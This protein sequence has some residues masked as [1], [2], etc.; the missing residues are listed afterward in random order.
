[1][2]QDSDMF[3]DKKGMKFFDDRRG[4]WCAVTGN[5]YTIRSDFE[6]KPKDV[7]NNQPQAVLELLL[8]KFEKFGSVEKAIFEAGRFIDGEF[9]CVA[10]IEG[11]IGVFSDFIGS[12]PIWYIENEVGT[13]RKVFEDQRSSVLCHGQSLVHSLGENSFHKAFDVLDLKKEKKELFHPT[14]IELKELFEDAVQK[15]LKGV[16]KAAV[17]FSGGVDSS[18]VAKCVSNYCDVSLFVAGIPGAKDILEAKIAANAMDLPLTVVEVNLDEV[19]DALCKAL[20]LI[21][22]THPM[23]AAIAV[24]EYVVGMEIKQCGLEV[25][26]SGQGSDEL[27]CSYHSS[28]E[29]L[30]SSGFEGVEKEVL[31]KL[32]DMQSRNLIRDFGVFSSFEFD[33]RLPFLDRFFV[34]AAMGLPANEKIL[35]IDDNLRKHP[36]RKMAL[37]LGVPKEIANKP[38]KAMQY[39]SGSQEAINLIAKRNGFGRKTHGNK[40]TEEFLKS[41]IL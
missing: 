23:H 7:S 12:R 40:Y 8:E 16:K 39:G 36:V 19:E 11:T 13:P 28:L 35:S 18:T 31:Q 30:S 15:R 5:V 22:T 9:S 37:D 33:V 25:V 29:M 38:K 20:P 34:S 26:L 4:N 27:F 1:E 21:G 2:K 10:G 3:L 6:S 14:P 24:T 32:D 17:L 41:I